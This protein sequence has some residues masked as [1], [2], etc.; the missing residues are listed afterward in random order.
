M[1]L[2][3]C[4]WLTSWTGC[5]TSGKKSPM[6]TGCEIVG[7]VE[8]V[9][10]FCIKISLLSLPGVE[11][12][13][14]QTIAWSLYWLCYC[15]KLWTVW[16]WFRINSVCVI[17]SYVISMTLFQ[18]HRLWSFKNFVW[19]VSNLFYYNFAECVVCFKYASYISTFLCVSALWISWL[20]DEISIAASDAERSAIVDLFERAV[21]DYL[22]KEFLC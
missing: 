20:K 1:A 19:F 18:L 21:Q 9:W 8:L 17:C 22:C 13:I 4:E 10:L 16:N 14:Y 2:D 11:R 7:A 15:T 6:P 3:G 12:W 5:I